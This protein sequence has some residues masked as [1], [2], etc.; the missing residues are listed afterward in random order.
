MPDV[1]LGRLN[2]AI[3]KL[4]NIKGGPTLVDV[5]PSIVANVSANQPPAEE[6]YLQGWDKYAL[7]FFVPATAAQFA[8]T[9]LRNPA[10]SGVMI[11]IEK[12]TVE[13]TVAGEFLFFEVTSTTDL[14]NIATMTF[15]RWDRRSRAAPT[16]IA[17]FN[18]AAALPAN[19]AYHGIF[20]LSQTSSE[21]IQ[22]E[23]QECPVLP[24]DAFA[25]VF[26]IANTIAIISMWWRERPLESSE[27]T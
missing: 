1:W 15:Q 21:L 23:N 17:S 22:T 6:R 18:T 10:N 19:T 8:Q 13:Y 4:Y 20:G 5:N 24:G 25:C 2:R 12:C 7:R 27:L 16:A 9:Q 26:S 11:V 3:E 14:T